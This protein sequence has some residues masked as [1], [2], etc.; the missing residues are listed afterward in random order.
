MGGGGSQAEDALPLFA[1]DLG[2]WASAEAALPMITAVAVLA[3]VLAAAVLAAAVLAAA[4]AT[5]RWKPEPYWTWRL[6]QVPYRCSTRRRYRSH[7]LRHPWGRRRHGRGPWCR[8]WRPAVT[9]AVPRSMCRRGGRRQRP[10]QCR[11]RRRRR[12]QRWRR[13]RRRPRRQAP[14]RRRCPT[15][16]YTPRRI[17]LSSPDSSRRILLPWHCWRRL[18]HPCFA[19]TLRHALACTRTR[20][21]DIRHVDELGITVIP[22]PRVYGVE[23]PVVG[24]YFEEGRHFD[25][26]AGDFCVEPRKQ[27]CR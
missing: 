21:K 13:R 4:A 16:G 26:V 12:L 17:L 19:H 7:L 5:W 27:S 18:R 9:A 23:E 24:S 22:Q 6:R 15:A 14:P 2:P 8:R 10:W 3:A 1:G 25:V 11:R 20:Y